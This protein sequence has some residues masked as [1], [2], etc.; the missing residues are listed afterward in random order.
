MNIFNKIL[1]FII[2]FLIGLALFIVFI[3]LYPLIGLIIKIDSRGPILYKQD[4]YGKNFKVIRVYKFR[5]MR[6]GAD[7]E[8]AYEDKKSSREEGFKIKNDPRITRVGRVLR[9]LSI[10]E[11]PQVLNV[12]KGDL[13]VIGPRAMPLK[14]GDQ[15]SDWERKRM[16]VKQGITGLWQVSGRS[17]ISYEERI[18]LDLYYIQNWSFWL[19]LK[20]LALTI[21]KIFKGSGAY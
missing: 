15:L 16:E 19:E 13:S 8:K 17:D 4:R 7:K 18:K 9:K 2:D 6:T 11:L 12:L 5:T 14:E 21:L 10:D 20:I 3:P 1:K